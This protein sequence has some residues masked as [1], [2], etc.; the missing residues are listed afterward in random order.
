MDP[1]TRNLARTL[2]RYCLSATTKDV[3]SIGATPAAESLVVA[4]YEEL[5]KAG[6]FPVVN[7]LPEACHQ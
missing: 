5:I 2:S 6:A 7:M 4:L 3:I 1:R